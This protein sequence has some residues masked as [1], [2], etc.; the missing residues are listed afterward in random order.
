MVVF[1]ASY[2]LTY[3]IDSNYLHHLYDNQMKAVSS[4]KPVFYTCKSLTEAENIQCKEFN[5]HSA[6]IV[7]SDEFI[8]LN[9]FL[10]NK[11]GK[12]NITV[13]ETLEISQLLTDFYKKF[14][15]LDDY[16]ASSAH[17]GIMKSGLH[18]K[19]LHQLKTITASVF[20]GFL[21]VCLL[22][23]VWCLLY[24]LVGNPTH[25]SK[26]DLDIL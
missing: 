21:F 26:R 10:L 5:D 9:K 19:Y 8:K 18:D 15:E 23:F 3:T 17:R 11:S 22:D 20:W 7:N 12:S 1:F 2:F 25:A 13:E 16:K 4:I 24:L 14:P 6:L